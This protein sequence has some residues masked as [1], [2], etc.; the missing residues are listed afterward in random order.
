MTARLVEYARGMV[1][2]EG[3]RWHDGALWLSDTQGSRLWTDASGR[4]TATAVDQVPNGLWFLPDGRLVA[5]LMHERRVGVWSGTGWDTYADLS[6]LGA[7]PL[8]DVVG[9]VAGNLY[10]DDVAFNPAAGEPPAPGRIILVRPDGT[11]EVAAR[12]VEFPNGLALLDD[13]TTLVVAETSRRRLTAFTVGADQR[14]HSP[15]GYA[16]LAALVGEPARPDGIWPAGDGGVW[17]ATT[18]GQTLAHVRDGALVTAIPTAPEF[19]IACCADDD[20]G[21][22]VTLAD[23][24]GEPLLAAL[25]RGAVTTRA[26]IVRQEADQP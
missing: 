1:W 25:A 12:G 20:G 5:A 3:P 21:L 18:T 4:W 16:D 23:T 19:P 15:R 10:V 14:L 9:D 6:E 26:A 11:A 17:V 2:G 24:G 7:G 22:L 13:G 8:G